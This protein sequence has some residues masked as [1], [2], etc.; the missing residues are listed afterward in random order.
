[1]NIIADLH[2]HNGEVCGHATGSTYEMLQHISKLGIFMLANTDH[3]I[4]CDNT[5]VSYFMNN[6]KRPKELHGVRL[7][8]GVEVDIGDYEGLLMME[9]SDLLKLDWVIASMHGGVYPVV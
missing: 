3:R 1:L 8:N 2:T 5:P 7:L 9:T 6:L 4:V